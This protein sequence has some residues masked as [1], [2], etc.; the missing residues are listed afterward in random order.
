MSMADPASGPVVRDGLG[1]L[2]TDD[3]V[4]SDD[5]AVRVYDR[6]IGLRLLH[7]D[8]GSGE[9]HYL[10][11][12]AAGTSGRWHRHTAAHTIVVLEGRLR[13]NGSEIGPHAY[14]HFVAGEPMRHEPAGDGPCLFLNLFHGPSNVEVVDDPTV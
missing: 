6:P 3:R 9:E 10:V 11:R 13:V 2:V 1:S 8:P 5:R 4:V 14:C 12:Y 7:E